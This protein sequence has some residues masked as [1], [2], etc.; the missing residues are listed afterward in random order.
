MESHLGLM[1]KHSWLFLTDPVIVL[2]LASLR[3]F[4]LEIH[5]GIL[6]GKCSDL[7]KAPNWDYLVVKWL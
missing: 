4:F 2:M 1:L 3:A 5:L 6:M 7:M